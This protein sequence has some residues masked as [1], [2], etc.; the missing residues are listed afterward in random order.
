MIKTVVGSYPVLK[1]QQP[2]NFKEKVLDKLGLF[3]RFK[4]SMDRAIEAQLEAKIDIISD[5]QVRGDMV[6]IFTSQMYGFQGK[7]V[8]DRIEFLKPITFKDLKYT[9]EYV[10]SK[11]PNVGVKGLLTG[12]CTIASSVRVERYYSDNKD[13]NLIMD[14]ARALNKEAL[15]IQDYVKVIQIDEPIL[16]T[17]LYDMKVAKKAIDEITKGLNVPTAIHVCGNV[18]NIF[19]ELNEFN[20]DILDHEFASN[21]DNLDILE[22]CKKK[23]GFGCINTK[24]KTIDTIDNIKELLNEGIDII[25]QNDYINDDLD[26][27][28]II[29]PDCGMRLLPESVAFGKLKNMVI[30]AE[31]IEKELFN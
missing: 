6:D 24:L 23:V 17:G 20:V 4:K 29:D 3:D 18:K 8:V 11:N 10:K 28:I 5:G 14:L 22:I 16:S 31:E 1:R 9:N 12:A 25:K 27:N 13:E 26:N 15:S 19:E 2:Q 7:K 30:A 21:R